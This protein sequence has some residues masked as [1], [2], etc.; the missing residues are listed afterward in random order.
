MSLLKTLAGWLVALLSSLIPK[1]P[2]VVITSMWGYRGGARAFFE[3]VRD[4]DVPWQP[5]WIS[6]DPEHEQFLNH[7]SVPFLRYPGWRAAWFILRARWLVSTHGELGRYKALRGQTYVN[8]WHGA[9]MKADG[10]LWKPSQGD[11]YSRTLSRADVTVA[12]S[13]FYAVI[14]AAQFHVKAH[15]IVAT[16][17]PHNDL[18]RDAEAARERLNE[19]V[20]GAAY[21]RIFLYAPS[22][23]QV[24]SGNTGERESD[25]TF[26]DFVDKYLVDDLLAALDLHRALLAIKLHPNE[27]KA[28][29]GVVSNLPGGSVRVV[30]SD[31][32]SARGLDLYEVLAGFD[33]LW[34]D[35]SSLATDFILTDRPMV[36]FCDDLD[37]YRERRG[38]VL[39][40][41]DLFTP[42]PRIDSLERLLKTLERA[43]A[44][45]EYGRDERRFYRRLYQTAEPPY[46]RNLI[47]L[48]LGR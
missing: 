29:G 31:S 13:P 20:D 33:M 22:H 43:V 21:E 44:D 11:Y 10:Y 28:Y 16:G 38:I 7:H 48:L 8:L 15:T 3:A 5:V 14:W 1:A 2:V 36:F 34:T 41:H 47:R 45:P 42:G 46:S 39:D 18:L 30:T 25:W 40:R 32:L 35:Y 24:L 26:Q 27:E 6:L 12:P 9:G 17:C 4:S 37:Q 19:I 23:R